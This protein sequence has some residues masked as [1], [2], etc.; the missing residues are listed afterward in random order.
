M[1]VVYTLPVRSGCT[2]PLA[3]GVQPLTVGNV[4]VQ[5]KRDDEGT[6]EAIVIE[7]NSVDLIYT[8]E[9]R[10]DPAPAHLQE[11]AYRIAT[12][13]ANRIYMQTSIDAI[14]PQ[15]TLL[16]APE[17]FP[18]D[19]DEEAEFKRTPR[20]MWTSINFG[21]SI[22]GTFDPTPYNLGFDHSAA[23]GYYADALR[24]ASLFQKFELLYKV[25]EY[26]FA[27]DGPALDKAVSTYASAY[28]ASFTP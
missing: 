3:S 27:E 7:F 4:S 5:W 1:K 19:P 28:D 11:Q 20:R 12:Y 18:E 26:F 13:I 15:H 2:A 16:H 22:R 14:D 23:H 21:Y 9:G 6:L 8:P 25:I 24:A 17:V 10:I